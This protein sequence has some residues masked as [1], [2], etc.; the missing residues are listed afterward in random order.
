[1][2]FLLSPELFIVGGGIS[3]RASEYLPNLKLQT[4]IVPAVF[5]NEAGIVGAAIQAF[6]PE[7]S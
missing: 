3:L 4:P 1:V 2:E 6:A 7:R 5:R